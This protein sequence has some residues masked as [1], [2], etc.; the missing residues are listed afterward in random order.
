L[1][2]WPASIIHPTTS[3]G[4]VCPIFSIPSNSGGPGRAGYGS[5]GHRRTRKCLVSSSFSDTYPST[6]FLRPLCLP[7]TA[8]PVGTGGARPPLCGANFAVVWHLQSDSLQRRLCRRLASVAGQPTSGTTLPGPVP[9][10][11][12]LMNPRDGL[13]PAENKDRDRQ[14]SIHETSPG[15]PKARSN[16]AFRLGSGRSTSTLPQRDSR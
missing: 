11:A 16:R 3:S 12:L 2:S 6:P 15:V 7:A 10:L 8:Y 1:P 5:P 13:Q 14:P 9:A 4:A